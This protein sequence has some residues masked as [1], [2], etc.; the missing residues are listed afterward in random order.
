MNINIFGSTGNIG[1]KSLHILKKYFPKISINLLTA[2]FNHIKLTNQANYFNPKYIHL[3][4]LSKFNY[5]KKNLNNKKIIILDKQD[6]TSY[7]KSSVSEL[8]ILAISGYQSLNYLDSILKNTNNLGLVNKE[9]IVSAGH[10]LFKLAKKNKCKIFPL[11]SEHYSIQNIIN[12]FN[13]KEINKIFLTA[14]GG[15]FYKLDFKDYANAT[16]EQAVKHPKWKMGYKN[17]IDSATMANKCLELVEAKYLFNIDYQYLDILI[18]PEALVHSIIELKNYTSQMSYFYP[19]M[20]IPLINFFNSKM[21]SINDN[22]NL[23]KIYKFNKKTTLNFNSVKAAKY[24]IYNLFKKLDKSDPLNL[25]KF[26]IANEHAVELFK[27]NIINFRDIHN[28]IDKSLS[29]SNLNLSINSIKNILYFHNY[30]E[31]LLYE[32]IPNV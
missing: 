5:L 18:H 1:T 12:K 7:L 6:L 4:D 24:P 32:K 16:F 11:D 17:S 27:N 19:D 22:D 29:I 21:L 8:S 13:F 28:I 2:N 3:N 15:P 9:S 25:I 14:S 20:S 30:Y 31:K 10:L 26:N 23:K